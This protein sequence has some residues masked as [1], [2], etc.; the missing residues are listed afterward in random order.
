[1]KGSHPSCSSGYDVLR[2]E[3]QVKF[4]FSPKL[5]AFPESYFMA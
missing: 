1:M 3:K 5:K 2:L 4:C